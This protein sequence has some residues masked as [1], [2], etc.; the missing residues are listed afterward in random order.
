MVVLLGGDAALTDELTADGQ[1]GVSFM[2]PMAEIFLQPL[3][4]DAQDDAFRKIVIKGKESKKQVFP[5]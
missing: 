1:N 4:G 3:A 2:H 5:L